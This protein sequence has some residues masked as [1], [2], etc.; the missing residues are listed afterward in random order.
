MTLTF[1]NDT[2]V[3]VYTLQKILSYARDN[4]YIF[5]AQSIWWISS[6]IGLQ[7]GWIVHIDDW[8]WPVNIDRSIESVAVK[9]SRITIQ[10]DSVSRILNS[11]DSL[12]ESEDNSVSTSES[13]IHDRILQQCEKF[14]EPSQKDRKFIGRKNQLTSKRVQKKVKGTFGDQVRGIDSSQLK[15]RQAA[16][17]CQRCAWP[18]D[19]KG[20]HKTMDC[21]RPQWLEKGTA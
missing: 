19:M 18:K 6:I 20:N 5:L 1:E 15:W 21:R 3:V 8:Q 13:D 9:A 17:E 16:G 10:S 11:N 7:Q 12:V 14:L 4:Q 2:E